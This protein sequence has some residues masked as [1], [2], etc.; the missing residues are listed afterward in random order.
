MMKLLVRTEIS[1]GRERNVPTPPPTAPDGAFGVLR[2]PFIANLMKSTAPGALG[3]LREPLMADLI[4]S[5]HPTEARLVQ[6]TP[7]PLRQM[8]DLPKKV[9]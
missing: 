7:T 5:T 9:Q 6:T 1:D 4:K 3:V 8:T 2:K